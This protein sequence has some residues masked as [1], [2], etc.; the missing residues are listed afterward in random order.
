MQSTARTQQFEWTQMRRTVATGACSAAKDRH[1]RRQL[2]AIAASGGA[3]S[4]TPAAGA[5]IAISSG[6]ATIEMIQI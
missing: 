4:A 3:S 1:R 5:A 6:I 2:G